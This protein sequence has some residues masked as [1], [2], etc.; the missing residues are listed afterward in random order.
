MQIGAEPNDLAARFADD[1][2]AALPSIFVVSDVRLIRDGLV[3]QLQRDGRLTVHGAGAPGPATLAA[4]AARAPSA[5]ALDLSAAG[6]F[7]FAGRLQ[8]ETPQ[9]KLV[10]FALGKCDAQL[11][12][13]ARTGVCGYV[14][15]EGTA[16]DIVVTVLHAL[17]GELY[18]SPRFAAQLLAQ[19]A[20]PLRPAATVRSDAISALTPRET[21]ILRE[22]R[23]GA[24]NKEIARL[25]GISAATV[26]N[27]VHHVLEKL[28]VRRRSQASAMLSGL[29]PNA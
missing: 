27:H 17:K 25:L 2:D 14:E 23:L 7:D 1:G 29:M 5:I 9:V 8:A 15:R 6:S 16:A 19:L 18:C 21:E 24:S 4:L 10:G 12:D 20:G 3:W 22:I 26:K 28:A 13:W 11:A